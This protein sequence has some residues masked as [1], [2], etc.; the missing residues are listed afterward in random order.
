LG[1]EGTEREVA[2]TV[3]AIL[4]VVDRQIA[5]TWVGWDTLDLAWQVG[6]VVVPIP[7]VDW[8]GAPSGERTGRPR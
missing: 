3:V 2:L 1:A 6:L 7:T 8:V 5:E 4:S